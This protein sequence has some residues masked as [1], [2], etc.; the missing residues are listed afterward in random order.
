MV[1]GCRH[2]GR[3]HAPLCALFCVAEMNALDPVAD[4]L[5]PLIRRVASDKDGEAQACVRAIECR[6]GKA[7]LTIHDLADPLTATV[8]PAQ[9]HEPPVFYDC[10]TA[11]EWMVTSDCGELSARDMRFCEDVRDILYRWPP[12]PKQAARSRSPVAKSGGRFDG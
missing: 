5:D 1:E 11:V 6:L 12:G 10:L 4:R 9:R 8:T 7:G 3:R 2:P